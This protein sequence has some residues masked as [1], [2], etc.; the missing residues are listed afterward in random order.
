L[1]LPETPH[2]RLY[3]QLS[4]RN[5]TAAERLTF[6]KHDRRLMKD[7]ESGFLALI[8][9]GILVMIIGLGLMISA[10]RSPNDAAAWMIAQEAKAPSSLLAM[11]VQPAD[12]AALTKR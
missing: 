5:E 4:S 2:E 10:V 8:L 9:S 7:Y 3:S 6:G 1:R 12:G 11:R